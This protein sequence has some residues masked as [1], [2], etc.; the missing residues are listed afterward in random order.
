VL[1][2]CHVLQPMPDLVCRALVSALS[3]H[4]GAS[5]LTP[6]PK[7]F[8]FFKRLNPGAT[9][10]CVEMLNSSKPLRVGSQQARSSVHPTAMARWR[11][12]RAGRPRLAT[13]ADQ[14]SK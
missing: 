13:P 12:E 4:V 1:A 14:P 5:G 9:F 6:G 7:S 8:I 3:C 10:F 2:V 11:L